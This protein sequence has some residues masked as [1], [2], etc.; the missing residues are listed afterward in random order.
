MPL[1]HEYSTPLLRNSLFPL[2]RASFTRF[3][4]LEIH[5]LRHRAKRFFFPFLFFSRAPSIFHFPPFFHIFHARACRYATRSSKGGSNEV[6]RG[7]E[8]GVVY[9]KKKKKRERKREKATKKFE[10]RIKFATRDL[11]STVYARPRVNATPQSSSIS[12]VEMRGRF[13][14]ASTM[15]IVR[16][17]REL[18]D[19]Y[20]MVRCDRTLVFSFFEMRNQHPSF[21]LSTIQIKNSTR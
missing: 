21:S 8:K 4:G 15:R 18:C 6:K 14:S 9:R 7:C 11:T 3:S 5:P 20:A 12:I 16:V 2:S 1:S 13:K 19:N 17:S 10:S